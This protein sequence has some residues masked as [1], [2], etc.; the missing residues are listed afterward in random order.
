M[1]IKKFVVTIEDK[2][3]FKRDVK[4]FSTDCSSAVKSFAY[5]NQLQYN[6]GVVVDVKEIK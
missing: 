2:N 4:V 3:G 1:V 6:D 5:G